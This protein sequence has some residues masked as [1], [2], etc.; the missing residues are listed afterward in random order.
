PLA[1]KKLRKIIIDNKVDLV[2]SSLYWSTVLARFACPHNLPLVSSIQASLT[3]SVEYKKKWIGWL[4]RF[5]YNRRSNTILG[6]SQHTLDDYFHFL[7]LKK[8]N[9]YLLYNFVDTKKYTV[10][11]AVSTRNG[12]AFRLITVG[13]LKVQ[14]NHRFL[15]EAFTKLKGQNISLDIYGDGLLKEEL[16]KFINE[17]DLPVRLMG[18]VG[19]LNEVIGQYDLFVMPSIYEG[20]SL[21]V[22]EGM[23][24]EKPM[25]LSDTPTF[26]EQA[27]GS[28]IYFSLNNVDDLVEKILL[29]KN[30]PGKLKEIA[31]KGR[32]RAL[33]NFTLEH[34]MATLRKI[35]TEILG[36]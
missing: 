33:Q 10:A 5:S 13:S 30:D 31:I 25:L 16:A 1:I 8:Q 35:Y 27:A 9:A 23:V 34:H 32:D 4:D 3:D 28:A 15:L 36:K 21:A 24:M 26:V 20:F 19:N 6:V 18:K 17:N 12:N 29:L 7:K 2:H 11:S 14:K 22:L